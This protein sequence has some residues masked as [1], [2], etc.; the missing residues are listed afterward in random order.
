MTNINWPKGYT[1]RKVAERILSWTKTN[2]PK[3]TDH[4]HPKLFSDMADEEAVNVLFKLWQKG[5]VD[6]EWDEEAEAT[7]WKLT[8]FGRELHEEKLTV[9]YIAAVDNIIQ[10]N[11]SYDTLLDLEEY[12]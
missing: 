6:V 3:R 4:P 5:I 10:L 9:P 2:P 1:M 12:R 8:E 7:R 11:A